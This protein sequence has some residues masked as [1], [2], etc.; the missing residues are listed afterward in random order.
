MKT[1]QVETYSTYNIKVYHQHRSV[2]LIDSTTIFRAMPFIRDINVR[3]CIIPGHFSQES[4][5]Y[6]R[7]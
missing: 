5:F 7:A 4:H 3:N 6:A 2:Q 1:I